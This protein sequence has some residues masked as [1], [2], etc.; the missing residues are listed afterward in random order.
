M[1]DFDQKR[2]ALKGFDCQECG[3]WVEK[4][5]AY[6][7]VRRHK[8]GVWFRKKI[9]LKCNGAIWRWRKSRKHYCCDECG[10][11]IKPGDKYMN[12]LLGYKKSA[13]TKRLCA[14]CCS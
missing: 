3:S 11:S 13:K 7:D 12:I 8:S 1:S 6:V 2:K 4:G 5:T 10:G 14:D 9:C